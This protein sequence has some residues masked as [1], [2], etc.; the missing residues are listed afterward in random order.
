[1]NTVENVTLYEDISYSLKTVIPTRQ[2]Y[3][4]NPCN[5]KRVVN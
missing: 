4:Y 3:T 5:G 2:T 1:M